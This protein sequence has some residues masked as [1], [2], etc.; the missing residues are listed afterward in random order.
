MVLRNNIKMANKVVANKDVS[1]F[2]QNFYWALNKGIRYFF[3]YR[4]LLINF[5]NKF[6]H[7]SLPKVLTLI[8]A[9]QRSLNRTGQKSLIGVTN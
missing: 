9:S 1:R 3:N 6:E 4:G 8:S 7:I 5:H 2:I